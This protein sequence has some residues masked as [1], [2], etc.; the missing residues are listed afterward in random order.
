M[1]NNISQEGFPTL[2]DLQPQNQQLTL[3]SLQ[4]LAVK[5]TFSLSTLSEQLKTATQMYNDAFLNHAQYHEAQEKVKE[6]TKALKVVKEQIGRQPA[7]IELESKMTE[8]KNE[9][10][11]K[12][13]S[14][15]SYALEIFRQTGQTEF[16]KD[17]EVYEIKTVAKLVKRK[18]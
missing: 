17:G 12:K 13:G 18:Q 3:F 2:E 10:K 5:N 14:I 4:D 6:A 1:D 7:M 9:M 16:D 11:E 15:S 8:I